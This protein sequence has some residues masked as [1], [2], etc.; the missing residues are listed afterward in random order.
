[1]KKYI[2]LF[3]GIVLVDI[4]TK[5]TVWHCC[6]NEIALNKGVSWS[7]MHSSLPMVGLFVKVIVAL[8]IAFFAFYVIKQWRL[9][10]MLWGE[11]C[12]L[13]GAVSNFGDRLWYGG[14]VDFIQIGICGYSW[15]VFNVAD[16][17]IVAGAAIMLWK[18]MWE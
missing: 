5:F 3:L 15:P 2:F 17:A 11:V 13:A 9:N 14:V 18:G 7:L 1:M 12:V 16:I 4:I 8:F 6:P 10:R